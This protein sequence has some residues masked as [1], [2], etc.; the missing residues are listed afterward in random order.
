ME[1]PTGSSVTDGFFNRFL[2]T[3]AKRSKVLPF[4]GD[5]VCLDTE[6]ASLRDSFIRRKAEV[7]SYGGEPLRLHLSAGRGGV[8]GRANSAAERPEPLGEAAYFGVLGNIVRKIEPQT[9]ADPAAVLTQLLVAAGSIIGRLCYYQV[10]GSRQ[11][12][13]LYDII[14]G[15]TGSAVKEPPGAAL[16]TSSARSTEPGPSAAAALLSS[17][18]IRS[19]GR[20]PP[21]PS[22]RARG[23]GVRRRPTARAKTPHG[24][25]SR[26][27]PLGVPSPPASLRRRVLPRPMRGR[28]ASSRDGVGGGSSSLARAGFKSV[29]YRASTVSASARNDRS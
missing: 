21:A 16:R 12:T 6:L 18:T 4:G 23:R 1:I 24:L 5:D 10:D 29:P 13:N 20:R 25:K 3:F 27:A 19:C 15:S 2:W 9:E 28:P 7:E 17:R 22:R 14:C 26:C 11:F 8:R